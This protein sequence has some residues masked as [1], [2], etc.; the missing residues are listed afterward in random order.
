MASAISKLTQN[1]A[2]GSTAANMPHLKGEAVGVYLDNLR[3]PLFAAALSSLQ[4]LIQ[5]RLPLLL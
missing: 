2:R 3:E 1:V 4:N 5:L